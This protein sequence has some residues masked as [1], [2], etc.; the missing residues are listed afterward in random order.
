MHRTYL[1]LVD[2]VD[3]TEDFNQVSLLSLIP[4]GVRQALSQSFL[5]LH[6]LDTGVLCGTTLI[7]LQSRPCSEQNA[8]DVNLLSGW[9]HMQP[10]LYLAIAAI[11]SAYHNKS[12]TCFHDV[13]HNQVLSQNQAKN[14]M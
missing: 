2:M 7:E 10:K 8:Y 11:A 4:H 6:C 5:S 12:E 13:F 14:G 9:Y 3:L 1:G